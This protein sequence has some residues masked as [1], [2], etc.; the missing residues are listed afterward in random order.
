MEGG[1]TGPTGA[2][3]RYIAKL[4]DEEIVELIRL[5]ND[6]IRAGKDAERRRAKLMWILNNTRK[7][8]QE[9][10]G[11]AIGIRQPTVSEVLRKFKSG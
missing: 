11:K 6:T 9:R 2:H 4:T 1:P 10:I 7:W 8:S 5:S 3:E